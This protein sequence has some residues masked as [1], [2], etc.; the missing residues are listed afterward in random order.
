MK[1]HVIMLLL[2]LFP[3]L[4]SME[5]ESDLVPLLDKKEVLVNTKKDVVVK[6]RKQ[7]RYGYLPEKL[8]LARRIPGLLSSKNARRKI[9]E[10][11]IQKESHLSY[12]ISLHYQTKIDALHNKIDALISEKNKCHKIK[13]DTNKCIDTISGSIAGGCCGAMAGMGI[14]CFA[15]TIKAYTWLCCSVPHNTVACDA[16]LWGFPICTCS[17]CVVGSCCVVTDLRDNIICE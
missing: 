14:A 13:I 7:V 15:L 4:Y 1:H 2:F 17:G 10:Y 9:I 16:L 11:M 3:N 8:Y 5:L 12:E 6:G